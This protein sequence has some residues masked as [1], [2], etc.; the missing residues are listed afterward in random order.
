MSRQMSLAIF[1]GVLGT[2]LVT[3]VTA[4]VGAMIYTRRKS[5]SSSE[6][7][8][9]SQKAQAVAVDAE[10]PSVCSSSIDCDFR[11]NISHTV[12]VE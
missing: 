9:E 5:V 10:L 7:D 3:M 12:P 6:A 11:C 1:I 8:P 2:V 4:V